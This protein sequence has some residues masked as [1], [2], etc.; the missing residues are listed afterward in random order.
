VIEMDLMIP[1][2]GSGSAWSFSCSTFALPSNCRTVVGD[3][4]DW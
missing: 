3:E 2:G 1:N 4:G